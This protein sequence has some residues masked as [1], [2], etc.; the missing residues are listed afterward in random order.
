MFKSNL[1]T[2]SD[3]VRIY[4]VKE[5]HL[6]ASQKFSSRRLFAKGQLLPDPGLVLRNE[7]IPKKERLNALLD[8]YPKTLR[9]EEDPYSTYGDY[10]LSSPEFVKPWWIFSWLLQ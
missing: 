1:G 4:R 5:I 10:F 6:G 3:V 8:P 7:M 9:D 2:G